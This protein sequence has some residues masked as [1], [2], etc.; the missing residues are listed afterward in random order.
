MARW[1]KLPVA[2]ALT[3]LLS[4]LTLLLPSSV[5]SGSTPS[6][7]AFREDRRTPTRGSDGNLGPEMNR[8]EGAAGLPKKEVSKQGVVWAFS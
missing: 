2:L 6:S 3:V 5:H 7:S 8:L 4:L 1:P